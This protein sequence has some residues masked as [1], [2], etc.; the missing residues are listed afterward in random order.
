MA[1]RITERNEQARRGAQA[2]GLATYTHEVVEAW[3]ACAV[4][5]VTIRARSLRDRVC[6]CAGVRWSVDSGGWRRR[7]PAGAS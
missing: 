1:D 2:A 3:P 5:G 7:E 4:C 6:G